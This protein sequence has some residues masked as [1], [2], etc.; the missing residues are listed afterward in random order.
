MAA[1]GPL[2]AATAVRK[3]AFRPVSSVADV[4]RALK[5]LDGRRALLW[6]RADWSISC[7][8]MEQTTFADS[9]V[10]EALGNTTCLVADVTENDD[11]DKALLEHF[12]V[13]GPPSFV[14]FDSDGQ[15]IGENLVGYLPPD[16]FIAQ[17]EQAFGS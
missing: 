10:I 3:L 2:M 11:D 6:I 16:T 12:G 1:A 9:T 14:L 15:R 8:E 7:S 4:K 17:I 5:Q 13:F